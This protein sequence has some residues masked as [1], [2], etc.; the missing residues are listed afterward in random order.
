MANY[1]KI[2]S[3]MNNIGISPNISSSSP[4]SRT[5]SVA[6]DDYLCRH[7]VG[8]SGYSGCDGSRKM[9][10][11][12]MNMNFLG[13]FRLCS[14]GTPMNSP[15][16][17]SAYTAAGNALLGGG[18]MGGGV[19]PTLVGPVPTQGY[20]M[21]QQPAASAQAPSS[22]RASSDSGKKADG[23]ADSGESTRIT[24]ADTKNAKKNITENKGYSDSDAQSIIDAAKEASNGDK[25]KFKEI[26]REL[27]K[28]PKYS[29]ISDEAEKEQKQREF[30]TKFGEWHAKYLG[31]I[32]GAGRIEQLV[33]DTLGGG[34]LTLKLEKD[35]AAKAGVQHYKVKGPEH[36][37]TGISE[38]SFKNGKWYRGSECKPETE[39]SVKGS[40]SGEVTTITVIG[41]HSDY[42]V[43]K[44]AGS[45]IASDGT[46]YNKYKV[47][48][49]VGS[50]AGDTQS[51]IKNTSEGKFIYKESDKIWR[52][53]TQKEESYIISG[54]PVHRDG[55]LYF[56]VG[57]VSRDISYS[58]DVPNLT[59]RM[60]DAEKDLNKR[61]DDLKEPEQKQRESRVK[62]VEKQF[63]DWLKDENKN[64]LNFNYNDNTLTITCPADKREKV[65]RALGVYDENKKPEYGNNMKKGQG[66]MAQ[67]PEDTKVYFKNAENDGEG[68]K[69]T[70]TSGDRFDSLV[71]ELKKKPTDEEKKISRDARSV[72][73]AK[74]SAQSKKSVDS[75]IAA[76]PVVKELQAAGAKFYY[77]SETRPPTL[78]VTCTPGQKSAVKGVLAKY[79]S[80]NSDLKAVQTFNEGLKESLTKDAKITFNGQ[81]I[82][83][84]ENNYFAALNPALEGLTS[85]PRTK[86]ISEPV[87]C[88]S[89][90]NKEGIERDI[91]NTL[92]LKL[93]E[94]YKNGDTI[95]VFDGTIYIPAETSETGTKPP[96]KVEITRKDWEKIAERLKGKY[97]DIVFKDVKGVKF[98]NSRRDKD[99]NLTYEKICW[100]YVETDGR[101][102]PPTESPAEPSTPAAKPEAK[103]PAV[104]AKPAGVGI[105]SATTPA[106]VAI[107]GTIDLK[108]LTG[109]KNKVREKIINA[110]AAKIDDA[111][112]K[113]ANAKAFTFTGPILLSSESVKNNEWS[114]SENSGIFDNLKESYEPDIKIDYMNVQ[115][116]NLNGQ[117]SWLKLK[118]SP[119]ITYVTPAAPAPKTEAAAAPAAPTPAAAT[120]APAVSA[121]NNIQQARD[122]FQAGVKSSNEG[123][124]DEAISNFQNSYKLRPHGVTQM[125]I[126]LCYQQLKQHV[127]AIESFDKALGSGDLSQDQITQTQEA[128]A[129]SQETLKQQIDNNVIKPLWKATGTDKDD[130]D[131]KYDVQKN[132][133]EITIP[134]RKIMQI[135]HQLREPT[136]QER[137]KPIF[138]QMPQGTKVIINGNEVTDPVTIDSFASTLKSTNPQET[139]PKKMAD[140][141]NATQ[142]HMKGRELYQDKDYV[143]AL[144]NF[145]LSNSYSHSGVTDDCIGLCYMKLGNYKEAIKSFDKALESGELLKKDRVQATTSKAEAEKLVQ[146][147][148]SDAA[149][150]ANFRVTKPIDFTEMKF[151]PGLSQR[152]VNNIILGGLILNIDNAKKDAKIERLTGLVYVANVKLPQNVKITTADWK[153]IWKALDA[154]YGVH[155]SFNPDQIADQLSS[156]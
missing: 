141:S 38:V 101:F 34:P 61:I 4:I 59:K 133:L 17:A 87:D 135:Y 58:D 41:K 57:D 19:L 80:D 76:D 86:R 118:D 52:Y 124:N 6:S 71:T 140:E 30:V 90:S 93:Q 149:S 42:M 53:L 85:S 89:K 67:L 48:L 70:G 117:V 109:S 115:G 55:R 153:D 12:A 132:T 18:L 8:A 78:C 142:Y 37:D 123:K 100:S 23:A 60:K 5:G 7:I 134:D 51:K 119:V 94:A 81:P 73:D 27:P 83:I 102:L 136:L 146:A 114:N 130:M 9:L 105:D 144:S 33:R 69:L 28:K 139:D 122:L 20:G 108:N 47:E 110:L 92:D 120:A 98:Y 40:P 50:A 39:L 148:S 147:S 72:E 74:T 116:I 35:G 26:I 125:N 11:N 84:T 43:I 54:N 56:D 46:I 21:P 13:Q 145:G 152:K 96:K 63:K 64:N 44:P 143:N 65:L 3:M 77:D 62:A 31:K 32:E 25:A 106:P 68:T 49:A 1:F 155:F 154:H 104:P 99:G 91:Y 127:N 15:S 14:A 126:G 66:I 138:D 113:N 16:T 107:P 29:D 22:I 131:Y 137:L 128:K 129:K 112:I 151:E 24:P 156:D 97:P 88:R 45:R 82:E 121:D 10:E 150:S 2:E 111:K 95:V 36:N 75:F 103:T 79:N